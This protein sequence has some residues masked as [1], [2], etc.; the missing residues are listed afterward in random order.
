MFAITFF[1]T[2]IFFS[3]MLFIGNKIAEYFTS[4]KHND[5]DADTKTRPTVPTAHIGQYRH[6]A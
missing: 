4:Q 2:V 1:A 5:A 3:V 6:I